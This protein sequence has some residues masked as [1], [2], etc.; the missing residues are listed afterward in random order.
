MQ[1][2]RSIRTT[3]DGHS[4]Q[5]REAKPV[6][7]AP[8]PSP[9]GQQAAKAIVDHINSQ[10]PPV[11]SKTQEQTIREMI[12]KAHKE[13]LS[14]YK[15]G[16]V[17]GKDWVDTQFGGMSE[18]SY[19]TMVDRYNQLLRQQVHSEAAAALKTYSGQNYP[20]QTIISAPPGYKEHQSSVP[21]D[22]LKHPG[23]GW[24]ANVIGVSKLIGQ[25]V[26]KFDLKEELKIY[27]DPTLPEDVM[28]TFGVNGKPVLIQLQKS[29]VAELTK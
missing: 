12:E 13:A 17:I 22:A 5:V 4:V 15:V 6:S 2:R 19:Q 1:R 18:Q 25:A 27:V 9:Y 16:K 11:K 24:G 23:L 28:V 29:D 3:N 26:E 10:L 21:L 7:Q 14:G 8:A 20:Q